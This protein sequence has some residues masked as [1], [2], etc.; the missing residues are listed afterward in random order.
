VE[1]VVLVLVVPTSLVKGSGGRSSRSFVGQA[2]F[3]LEVFW[4]GGVDVDWKRFTSDVSPMVILNAQNIFED[5]Y[6]D[7]DEYD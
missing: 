2:V 3:V 1:L 4:S 5:E 6:D 7:E